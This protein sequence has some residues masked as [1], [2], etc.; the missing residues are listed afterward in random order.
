MKVHF[1]TCLSAFHLWR[2]LQVW[3]SP[4]WCDRWHR[5]ALPKTRKMHVCSLSVF[6]AKHGQVPGNRN[7]GWDLGVGMNSK[8][9]EHQGK[10]QWK[11]SHLGLVFWRQGC[12]LPEF[13]TELM[14][15]TVVIRSMWQ[16]ADSRAA[17]TAFPANL[18]RE[19]TACCSSVFGLMAPGKK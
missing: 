8:M 6:K 18:S 17:G 3:R 15:D 11:R 4:S 12:K 19:L 7:A 9:C 14:Q 16:H 1:P 5:C 2:C 13:E 10:S